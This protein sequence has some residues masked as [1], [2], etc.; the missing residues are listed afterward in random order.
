MGRRIVTLMLALSFLAL[1]PSAIAQDGEKV[2]VVVNA[3]NDAK[4][5]DPSAVKNFYL[6]TSTYWPNGQ[7]VAVFQRGEDS[8]ASKAFFSKVLKM[9]PSRFRHH[10]QTLELSGQGV[11]PENAGS[12]ASIVSKVA[13]KSGGIGFILESEREA[14]AGNGKVRVIEL[15]AE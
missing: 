5:V 10:W 8:A 3:A 12:A 14:A 7:R 6:G 9:A 1:G 2:L 15:A 13:G 11:A 4:S